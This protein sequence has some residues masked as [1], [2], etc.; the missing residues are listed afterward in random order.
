MVGLPHDAQREHPRPE[1]KS[2]TNLGQHHIL[3]TSAAL[4]PPTPSAPP[5][6]R[7]VI[8]GRAGRSPGMPEPRASVYACLGDYNND[9]SDLMPVGVRQRERHGGQRFSASRRNGQLEE[10]FFLFA[11]LFHAILEDLVSQPSQIVGPSDTSLLALV[12][13]H[14]EQ[15]RRIE[16]DVGTISFRL[17]L[18]GIEAVGVDQN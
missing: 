12:V 4:I 2:V 3:A 17:M 14:V 5:S 6:I 18:L 10:P 13:Q 16:F 15:N 8:F 7:R 1:N 9:A 11:T